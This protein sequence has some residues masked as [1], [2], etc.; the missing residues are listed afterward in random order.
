[1]RVTVKIPKMGLTIEDV[2]VGDW[3]RSVGD[4][5][6]ADELLVTVEADKASYEIPA[7]A[8]GVLTEIRANTGE[9]VEVGGTI[10]V[11]ETD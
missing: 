1:M 6:E 10:A 11:I 5:I 9:T 7:A 4:R 8:S 2:V 3:T